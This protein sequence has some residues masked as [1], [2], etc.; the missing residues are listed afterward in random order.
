[1]DRIP[2][3]VQVFRAVQTGRSV[4]LTTHLLLVPS[5][6]WV[7]VRPLPSVCA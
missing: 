2:V 4:V 5:C 7:G 1:M 3:G 6:E